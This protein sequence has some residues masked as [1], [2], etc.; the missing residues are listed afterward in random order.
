MSKKKG[1]ATRSPEGLVLDCSIVMAWYFVDERSEYAD[2]VARRLPQQA[3]FV[4]LNWPLEVANVL[5]MGERRKRSTQTQVAR[6]LKTLK[7]LPSRL[8]MRPTSTPGT[9]R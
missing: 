2:E 8:T 9:S 1:I 5:F 3:A 6:L 7:S 4:P